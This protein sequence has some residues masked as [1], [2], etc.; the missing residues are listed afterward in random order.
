VS[1]TSATAGPLV[2]PPTGAQLRD[3]VEWRLVGSG[4]AR[5]GTFRISGFRVEPHTEL[6]AQILTVEC[7]HPTRPNVHIDRLLTR[8]GSGTGHRI[9]ALPARPNVLAHLIVRVCAVLVR[10]TRAATTVD[11][12]APDRHTWVTRWRFDRWALCDARRGSK[13]PVSGRPE[14]SRACL[15]L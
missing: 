14:P 3:L 7:S 11:M 6:A 12:G 10:V 4:L 2:E 1:D 9:A 8:S 5:E 13:P 15:D